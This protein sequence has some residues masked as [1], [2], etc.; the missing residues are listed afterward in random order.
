MAQYVDGF[1]VPVPAAKLEQYRAVS[2]HAGALWREHGAPDYRECVAD[3]LDAHGMRSMRDAAGAQDGEVVV[4]A[5]IVYPDR[6]SRDAINTKVMND[7]R[8][9]HDGCAGIFDFSRMA[10]AG[11]KTIVHE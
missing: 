1:L 8:M 10:C 5:W 4:F 9:N 7:P 6:A 11:F 3:D 2:A